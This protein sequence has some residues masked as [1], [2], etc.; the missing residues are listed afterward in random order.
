MAE[1]ID[2]VTGSVKTV[3]TQETIV[4][5]AAESNRR[6]QSQTIGTA[7]RL[8]PLMDA[9]GSCADNEANYLGVLDGTFVSHPD[10]DTYA[11]SFLETMVQPQSLR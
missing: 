10:A 2:F 1:I 11:V 8:P 3:Y 5:A 7:F 4:I 6:R 9:F